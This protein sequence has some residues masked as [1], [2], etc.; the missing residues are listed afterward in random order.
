MYYIRNDLL[1]LVF[2][3]IKLVILMME[4]YIQLFHNI[5]SPLH[6]RLDRRTFRLWSKQLAETSNLI[7]KHQDFYGPDDLL[8]EPGGPEL[9]D[10]SG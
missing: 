2:L 6:R 5:N 4:N 1:S 8:N 9:V 3:F 10:E 7:F